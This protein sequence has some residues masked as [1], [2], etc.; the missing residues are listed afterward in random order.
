[1]DTSGGKKDISIVFGTTGNIEEALCPTSLEYLWCIPAKYRNLLNA[2]KKV[3]NLE[4][5]EIKVAPE[6]GRSRSLQSKAYASFPQ[7]TKLLL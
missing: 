5:A 7:T 1:M 6:N 4:N 3:K 2:V